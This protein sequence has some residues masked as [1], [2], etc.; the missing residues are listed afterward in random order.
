MYANAFVPLK[1]AK[2][3]KNSTVK[4]WAILFRI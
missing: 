4:N 1:F 2:K 3:E